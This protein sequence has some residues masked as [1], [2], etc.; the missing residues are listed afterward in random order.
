[1]DGSVA[2]ELPHDAQDVSWTADLP[3][4]RWTAVGTGEAVRPG[5]D[6]RL[7]VLVLHGR[8]N[9][10]VSE[11]VQ[12]EVRTRF[13]DP[14]EVLVASVIDLGWVPRAIRPVARRAMRRVY[15]Q[16]WRRVPEGFDPRE[17][18]VMLPDWK[19]RL[20]AALDL[21]EVRK[22]AAVVVVDREAR[23]VGVYQGPEPARAAL[24]LLSRTTESVA[25]PT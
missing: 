8:H 10:E 1:M 5:R 22:T 16:V 2:M 20:P 3:D 13:P 18:V 7:A 23:V 12:R 11:V 15:D 6:G 21:R 19:A 17:C 14:S 25:Q 24:R 9:G 4:L